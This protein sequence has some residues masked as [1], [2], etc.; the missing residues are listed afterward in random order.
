MRGFDHGHVQTWRVTNGE[1]MAAFI[2]SWCHF[3]RAQCLTMDNR[4]SSF[5]YFTYLSLIGSPLPPVPLFPEG[6]TKIE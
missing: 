4:W 5:M 3:H 2:M 1:K 6:K